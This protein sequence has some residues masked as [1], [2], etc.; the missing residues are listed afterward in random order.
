MRGAYSARRGDCTLQFTSRPTQTAA[1]A[2][3]STFHR[4]V[5]LG[6]CE[7]V[8]S[9]NA[10]IERLGKIL[11]RLFATLAAQ[12]MVFF[13]LM[14][15]LWCGALAM[16]LATAQCDLRLAGFGEDNFYSNGTKLDDNWVNCG[17]S[18]LFPPQLTLR[19]SKNAHP[20]QA[21]SLCIRTTARNAAGT[22]C[23][24]N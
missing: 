13:R 5:L 6:L 11:Y 7:K 24:T 2:V 15:V 23:S 3:K 10:L 17:A 9:L 19:P 22:T 4:H 21:G 16:P 12:A 8:S 14:M 20:F 18:G 1:T